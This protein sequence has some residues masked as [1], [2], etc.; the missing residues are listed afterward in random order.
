MRIGRALT[1]VRVCVWTDSD[2]HNPNPHTTS[3]E[4][5]ISF[6][7]LR[8]CAIGKLWHI[9][10]FPECQRYPPRCVEQKFSAA[11]KLM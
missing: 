5:F 6:P 10:T 7:T 2:W 3:N 11:A 9:G 1:G 4:Y 8:Y